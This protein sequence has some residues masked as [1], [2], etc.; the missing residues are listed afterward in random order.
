MNSGN[1]VPDVAAIESQKG[2]YISVN[3]P[4]IYFSHLVF[5]VCFLW[6]NFYRILQLLIEKNITPPLFISGGIYKADFLLFRCL[7]NIM[8]ISA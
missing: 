1:V 7:Q 8:T 5:F 3:G 2:D 6:V 4:Y